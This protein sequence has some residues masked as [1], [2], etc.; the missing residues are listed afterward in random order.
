MKKENTIIVL[1]FIVFLTMGMISA[2]YDEIII[3]FPM[4]IYQIPGSTE[5]VFN[6]EF[7]VGPYEEYLRPYLIEIKFGDG[8]IFYND[9]T[10]EGIGGF[11]TDHTYSSP[12]EYSGSVCMYDQDHSSIY[13]CEDFKMSVTAPPDLIKF[14][15][16]GYYMYSNPPPTMTC[17]DFYMEQDYIEGDRLIHIMDV[18]GTLSGVGNLALYEDDYIE[19]NVYIC[20]K[21]SSKI[22]HARYTASIP[23]QGTVSTS[24]TSIN[25]DY[26]VTC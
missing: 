19:G 21:T 6:F 20:W 22:V 23:I 17:R 12:G 14:K 13:G 1:L 7:D 10:W 9:I 4:N 15:E 26:E 2:Y 25:S 16:N 8:E 24:P 3:E 11:E 18:P 5:V